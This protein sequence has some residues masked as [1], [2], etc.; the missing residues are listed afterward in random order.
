[1]NEAQSNY[2]HAGAGRP[3]SDTRVGTG[4]LGTAPKNS[5]L[6][7]AVNRRMSQNKTLNEL[8][9]RAE[10]L[11]DKW[12]GA[13]PQDGA[14]RSNIPNAGS[15]IGALELQNDEAHS[16]ITRLTIA[17]DRLQNL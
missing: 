3:L 5:R 15:L 6:E 7:E 17:L 4:T 16:S 9:A 2:L 12:C 14:E 8:A 10:H 1:M 11:A 13:Q